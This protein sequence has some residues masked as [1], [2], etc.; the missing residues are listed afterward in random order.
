M[1]LQASYAETVQ[2]SQFHI[3]GILLDSIEVTLIQKYIVEVGNLSVY[4]IS[5][6][7]SDFV[8]A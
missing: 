6:L 3:Q 4:R 1:F 2:Q 7:Y 8:K 5:D